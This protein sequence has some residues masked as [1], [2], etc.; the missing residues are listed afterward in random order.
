L[1]AEYFL[2][3]QLAQVEAT[4]APIAAENVPATQLVQT[5]EPVA[6]EINTPARIEVQPTQ[7]QTTILRYRVTTGS[8]NISSL[9]CLLL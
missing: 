2:A 3:T 1:A 5:V 7:P 6:A 8:M 4:V 9:F